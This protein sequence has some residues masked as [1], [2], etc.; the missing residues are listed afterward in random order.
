MSKLDLSWRQEQRQV[1]SQKMIQSAHILQMDGKELED[2][3]NELAL[4]NP[5]IELPNEETL[6]LPGAGMQSPDVRV[7]Y[8]HEEGRDGEQEPWDISVQTKDLYEYVIS[9]LIPLLQS[10]KEKQVMEYLVYSL[11]SKGY[12][13]LEKSETCESLKIDPSHYKSIDNL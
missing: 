11:D 8:N 3:V 12:L 5:L 4:E 7:Y 13:E 6:N 10:G 9:Q 2:Y 1:L